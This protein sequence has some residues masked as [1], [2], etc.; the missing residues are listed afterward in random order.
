M[1]DYHR[2]NRQNRAKSRVA[3]IAPDVAGRFG[4]FKLIPIWRQFIY[5]FALDLHVIR[6]CYFNPY[7]SGRKVRAIY[8]DLQ[9]AQR[10]TRRAINHP[11]SLAV[12]ASAINP[13]TFTIVLGVLR[14]ANAINQ[15]LLTRCRAASDQ[16]RPTQNRR[17]P[18]CTRGI[19]AWP[20]PAHG[21]GYRASGGTH[22]D[23][24]LPRW[25]AGALVRRKYQHPNR[26]AQW[27]PS[28]RF[29]LKTTRL[30]PPTLRLRGM[31]TADSACVAPSIRYYHLH[32]TRTP[33]DVQSVR[34]F[35]LALRAGKNGAPR[36][37][38]LTPWHRRK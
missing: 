15:Q 17:H 36:P 34:V 8:E 27:H 2:G 30:W 31:M 6:K 1:R 32:G 29:S 20:S 23:S 24:R 22:H 25:H 37:S 3:P 28:R 38:D 9:S 4:R 21:R 35:G 18:D 7:T 14:T 16:V 26:W 19:S 10:S 13:R 11:R 33:A 12:P 5:L